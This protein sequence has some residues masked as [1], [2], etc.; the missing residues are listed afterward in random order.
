MS[1]H[2]LEQVH[3]RGVETTACIV[4]R[5]VSGMCVCGGSSGLKNIKNNKGMQRFILVRAIKTLRPSADDR[6]TQEYPKSRGYSKM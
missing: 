1:K 2:I 4:V 5:L 3:C 6:N